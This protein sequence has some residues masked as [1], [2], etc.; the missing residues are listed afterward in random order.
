MKEKLER[1]ISDVGNISTA[2][3]IL[4]ISNVTL[5]KYLAGNDIPKVIW[6]NKISPFIGLSKLD[7]L[8]VLL[9]RINILKDKNKFRNIKIDEL[10]SNYF[11]LKYST[12][13]LSKKLGLVLE[14]GIGSPLFFFVKNYR[15][16]EDPISKLEKVIENLITDLEYPKIYLYHAMEEYANFYGLFRPHKINR[17]D[18]YWNTVGT[19]DKIYAY[20]YNYL[21][22]EPI[23]VFSSIQ[24]NNFILDPRLKIEFETSDW[25]VVKQDLEKINIAI[26]KTR[27]KESVRLFAILGKEIPYGLRHY[28]TEY[29]KSVVD[30]ISDDEIKIGEQEDAT[31]ILRGEKIQVKSE[32]ELFYALME[33]N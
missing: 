1:F 32:P 30:N 27:N 17:D 14:E 6:D 19:M 16:E 20:V 9:N 5:K 10:Y 11:S 28:I 15:Y 4:N 21:G 26:R 29:I 13:K 31:I 3:S 24:I 33:I 12:E 18:Y 7:I 8:K 23:R 2:S 22:V 25:K